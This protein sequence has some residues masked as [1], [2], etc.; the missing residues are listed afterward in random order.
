M[1]LGPTFPLIVFLVF[2]W[3]HYWL[4]VGWT[5]GARGFT[6]TALEGKGCG[7]DASENKASDE[8]SNPSPQGEFACGP[9][10]REEARGD[11]A[12]SRKPRGRHVRKEEA[13][14][15]RADVRRPGFSHQPR[16]TQS[17]CRLGDRPWPHISFPE[18]RS[19]PYKR[20]HRSSTSLTVRTLAGTSTLHMRPCPMGLG[21]HP[22]CSLANQE[23]WACV[24]RPPA[25]MSTSVQGTYRNPSHGCSR[26]SAQGRVALCRW[27]A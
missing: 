4:R 16:E 19:V 9:A 12:D 15:P 23:A 21:S 18:K 5:A 7:D 1:A 13:G 2:F 17:L 6:A 14:S 8:H 10:A 11:G 25:S 26:H 3:P 27:P 22:A 20:P 24:L